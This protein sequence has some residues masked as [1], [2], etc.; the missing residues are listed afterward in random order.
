M[1]EDGLNML[2]SFVLLG[3][4]YV[5]LEM[6]FKARAQG[7]NRPGLGLD[8]SYFVLQFMVMLGV[9]VALHEWLGATLRG[10]AAVTVTVA[11][12]A[13][14]IDPG[15]RRRRRTCIRGI[16]DTVA[17]GVGRA[18]VGAD[19]GARLGLRAAVQFVRNAVQVLVPRTT[20]GID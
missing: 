3:A 4:V 8:L 18:P 17:V 20:L 9:F 19:R 15:S 16:P 2:L 12:A 10:P 1:Q 13:P 7:R 11:R 14:G 6:T 5:P